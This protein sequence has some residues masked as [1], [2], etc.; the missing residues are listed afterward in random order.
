MGF[1]SHLQK[2]LG[3]NRFEI[4]IYG[5][6]SGLLKICRTD[7]EFGLPVIEETARAYIKDFK[8]QNPNETYNTKLYFHE[9]PKRRR[10]ELL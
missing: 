4:A 6:K 5:N 2:P 1:N 8:A 3:S 10:T 7:T 9:V